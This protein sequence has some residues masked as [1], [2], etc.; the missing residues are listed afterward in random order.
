MFTMEQTPVVCLANLAL[1]RVCARENAATRGETADVLA[2]LIG[3]EQML[4]IIAV[5]LIVLWLL[6]FVAFHITAAFIHVVL[7]VGVI[8]LVVHFMRSRSKSRAL[9]RLRQTAPPFLTLEQHHDRTSQ[10]D[11]VSVWPSLS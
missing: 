11:Q 4:G 6:G 8:L 1:R 9:G 7:V 3:E 5:V 10:R 2:G